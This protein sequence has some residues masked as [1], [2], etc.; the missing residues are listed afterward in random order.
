MRVVIPAKAGIQ[1][2][3]VG[4]D[5]RLRG[6]D[7]FSRVTLIE[8]FTAAFDTESVSLSRLNH[9]WQEYVPKGYNVTALQNQCS[10]DDF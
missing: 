2:R 4:V 10:G 5:S 6:N 9:L 8:Q 3:G 7:K 1:E